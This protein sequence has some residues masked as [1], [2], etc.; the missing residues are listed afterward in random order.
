MKT[1]P[2]S[3]AGSGDPLSADELLAALK[4]SE[5]LAT[6]G[7]T[8]QD[9]L[10]ARRDSDLLATLSIT[11]AC[12]EKRQKELAAQLRLLL[13]STGEGIYG[14]DME[15]RCNFINLSG[16][17]MSGF[18]PDEMQGEIIH[19]LNHHTRT[20]GEPYPIEECAIFRAFRTGE[21][22]TATDEVFWRKDGSSFPVEYS[23]YPTLENGVPSGAVIVFKDVSDRTKME[24]DLRDSEE[25][26][27]NAF[28]AGRVGMAL[29]SPDNR[30]L[31][32]NDS[33][34]E[35]VG[36]S[37]DE[38]L[39]IDW[40][41]LTHPDDVEINLEFARSLLAGAAEPH[42]L[43]KRYIHK[44]GSIITVDV[45]DAV[46]RD[47]EGNP[48]YFV[49]QIQ[50]VT[51]RK[52]AQIALEE[53]QKLL[54]GVIDN[55][56][57]VIYIKKVDGTYLLVSKNWLR[58]LNLN[59][60]QV[61]GRTDLDVFPRDLAEAYMKN[62]REVFD[63]RKALEVEE[64]AIHTDGST[65]TYRSLKF[66]LFD[67]NGECY[68]LCGISD[69]ITYRRQEEEERERLQSQLRQGQK[70][71][72]V[73]Q[74]AGG[75]AHDFNNILAVI[76]NYGAFLIED[77]DP[78]DPRARDVQ[79]IIMAGEKAAQLVHQLLAFSRK[80]VVKPVVVDLNNVVA[81]LRELLRSSI[82]EDIELV[83]DTEKNLPSILADTSQLEQ[84]LLNLSVNARDAMPRGGVLSI[85]TS[86]LVLAKGERLGLPAGWYVHL[87]VTD[88]GEG[89]DPGKMERVFE[90]FFTTKERGKG[91]GLGLA[92]VYGIVK[93]AGGGIYVD[94]TLGGGSSFTVF[95]PVTDRERSD[96]PA[97]TP[98][99][100]EASG[101]ETILVVEDEDG[102]RALVSRILTK[103]GYQ[104]IALPNGVEALDYCK[105]HIGDID[106]L[107]TDVVMPE[108]SGKDLAFALVSLRSD[109]KT[110]FM[111]GYTDEIIAQ[112]GILDEGEH[113]IMKPFKADELVDKV[114]LVLG[115]GVR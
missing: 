26:F 90:P 38:L 101:T 113:L 63:T 21:G 10:L 66:P 58:D 44:N 47:P 20:N 92:T 71:E 7:I 89:I 27:R 84:V 70:M 109:I 57:A 19:D 12:G 82:G 98:I 51:D 106:L 6:L 94:S 72:A 42:Q 108:M 46:V 75:I 86:S 37:R 77:L 35:M 114:R 54:R 13:D 97:A 80:E 68:A 17:H 41:T 103:S 100:M 28:V 49:T 62:D 55:S 2:V 32:V 56:P 5:A 95:L 9:L 59:P 96:P 87:S 53:S 61:V 3:L 33:L 78:E 31:T 23:S 79:E 60:G 30:Y 110:M 99:P 29:I 39:A 88:S 22:V 83:I 48:L 1:D 34:C 50:D 67:Q 93:Q 104:V 102:V 16:A 43:T 74:L 25:L 8:Q 107:L 15:G 40:M 65:H 69:D 36:Y 14:V 91:T 64:S 45:S 81:G 18:E 85:A 4:D 111:S 105:Q 24:H 115:A 112:R 11:L 76:L 73:G 52:E